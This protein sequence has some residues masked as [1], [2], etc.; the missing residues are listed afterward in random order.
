MVAALTTTSWNTIFKDGSDVATRDF[1]HENFRD[2]QFF[3]EAHK[4]KGLTSDTC[5]DLLTRRL[6]CA[7]SLSNKYFVQSMT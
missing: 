2:L 4:N 5:P 3:G 6:D 1:H 7:L